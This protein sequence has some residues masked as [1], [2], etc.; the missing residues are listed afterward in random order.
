MVKKFPLLFDMVSFSTSRCSTCI[1]W[2][3]K[4][5][6]GAALALRD[7]VLVVRER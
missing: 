1:Q 5:T 6:P 7:L 3:A 4:V 2:R